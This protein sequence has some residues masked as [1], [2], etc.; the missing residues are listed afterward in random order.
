MLI[1]ARDPTKET[2]TFR[3][4]HSLTS[5]GIEQPVLWA[6]HGGWSDNGSFGESVTDSS[7]AGIL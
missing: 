3:V 2:K 7:F 6:V 5:N 4:S 1:K